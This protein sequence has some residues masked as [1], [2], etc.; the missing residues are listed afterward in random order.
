[1]VNINSTSAT[2]VS[3]LVTAKVKNHKQHPEILKT[4]VFSTTPTS[5]FSLQFYLYLTTWAKAIDNI[6]ASYCLTLK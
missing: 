5:Y 1:L 6:A 3:Q 2:T 4:F